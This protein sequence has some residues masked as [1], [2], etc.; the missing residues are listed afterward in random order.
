ME[1][2][3]CVLPCHV[4]RLPTIHGNAPLPS[5]R[6]AKTAPVKANEALEVLFVMTISFSVSRRPAVCARVGLGKTA[7][8]EQIA[9]GSF[10]APIKIGPRASA[11]VDAEVD[12]WLE[13]RIAERDAAAAEG[14]PK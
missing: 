10:P 2:I 14:G 1:F 9:E 4:V 5:T 3:C 11:W 7:L 12:A 6:P 8:Y 13:A